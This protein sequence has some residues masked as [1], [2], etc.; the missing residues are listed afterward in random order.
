MYPKQNKN[1]IIEPLFS[2]AAGAAGARAVR[3]QLS[4][5]TG[6]KI[7]EHAVARLI[8]TV[9]ISQSSILRQGEEPTPA[10]TSL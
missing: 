10:L 9:F 2:A 4:A 6:M 8:C 5:R 7:P 3:L 1:Q